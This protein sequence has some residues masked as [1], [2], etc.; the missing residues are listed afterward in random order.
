LS[1]IITS[2]HLSTFELIGGW[3]G[4]IDGVGPNILF[5]VVYLLTTNLVWA[6]SSSLGVSAL[7]VVSRRVAGRPVGAAVVGLVLVAV[8]GISALGSGDGRDFFLPDMIQTGIVGAIFLLSIAVGRP[9][10]GAVLGPVVGGPHWRTTNILFRAYNVATALSVVLF[11]G[12]TMVKIP[13]Y[14]A[15]NVA[16]LGVVDLVTGP[17]LALL[18]AYISLWVV[19]RAYAS[20]GVD[21]EPVSADTGRVAAPVSKH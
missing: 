8:S 17:P 9:L 13:L 4:V 6:A 2:Q 7:L 18:T 21:A 15:D 5:V 12:R 11:A 10:L 20:A 14:M 3:R 16:A 19:R 1:K